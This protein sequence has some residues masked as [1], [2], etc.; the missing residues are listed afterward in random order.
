MS[1]LRDGAPHGEGGSGAETGRVCVGDGGGGGRVSEQRGDR[2]E[3]NKEGEYAMG[4][5]WR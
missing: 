5:G 2:S 3:S 1:V 4:K